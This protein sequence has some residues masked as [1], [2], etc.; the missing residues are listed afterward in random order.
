MSSRIRVTFVAVVVLACLALPA[1]A[2]AADSWPLVG[3]WPL[4]EGRGQTAYDWSGNGNHGQLGSTAGVDAND[5][6]WIRGRWWGSALSFSGDDFIRIRSSKA[7]EPQ[8]MTVSLWFRGN[9]SPGSYKYLIAKG[10]DACT[11]TSY[12]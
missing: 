4:D 3:W 1:G 5:P 7:L 11:A 9:G 12:G 10:S 2:S 6:S 8:Q